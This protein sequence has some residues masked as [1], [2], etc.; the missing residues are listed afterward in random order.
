MLQVFVHACAVSALSSSTRSYEM[1]KYDGKSPEGPSHMMMM[2]IYSPRHAP[3]F[4]HLTASAVST[5]R[6]RK[7]KMWY[8]WLLR[9]KER[10]S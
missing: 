5:R 8:G 2:M 7:V 1:E 6:K 3:Q 10:V 4:I 9:L